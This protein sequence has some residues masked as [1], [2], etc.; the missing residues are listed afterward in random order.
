MGA[1]RGVLLVLVGVLFF[2]LLLVG[3]VL[4][5]LSLSLQ[6]DNIQTELASSIKDVVMDE[7]NLEEIIEENYP[8]VELYCQNNSEFVFRED[9]SGYTFTISCDIIAQGPEAIVDYGINSLVEQ[10]YYEDYDCEFWD[11]IGKTASPLFLVSEKARNYWNSKFYLALMVSVALI[12][13]IFF[14]VEKKSNLFVIVGSLLIISALPFMKLDWV[15]SFIPNES[16]L[17]LL[18]VFF[19]KA[20]TEF[21][22]TL[23]SGIVILGV[24]ILLKLFRVGFKI[25]N[26]FSRFQKKGAKKDKNFFRGGDKQIVKKEV[27][28]K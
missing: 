27:S 9:S 26:L 15:L 20:Y 25:S 4:L 7:V 8:M 11:C 1:I 24:G 21:L 16:F 10:V 22:I 13:L 12:V 6:Y 23:I 17:E 3:N 2:I 19:T 28:K 18:A 14:L 5:I